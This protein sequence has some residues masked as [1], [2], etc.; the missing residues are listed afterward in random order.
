MQIMYR[1]G[2]CETRAIYLPMRLRFRPGVLF[3]ACTIGLVVGGYPIALPSISTPRWNI[4]GNSARG[5]LGRAEA[6]QLQNEVLSRTDVIVPS[7]AFNRWL[8]NK[9]TADDRK[10]YPGLAF[11]ESCYPDAWQQ[12]FHAVRDHKLIDGRV[13]SIGIYS[14]GED[15][16]STTG[17]QDVD[18]INSWDRDSGDNYRRREKWYALLLFLLLAV[19][20]TVVCYALIA[21][22][23]DR[24][25]SQR[26]P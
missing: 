14:L 10:T 16:G 13:I 18:D 25:R 24:R 8:N 6:I 12:P 3:V 9:L 11:E 19:P 15:G 20:T 2:G 26:L 5:L 4:T 17:G 7:E 22:A 23:I 21:T 1:E